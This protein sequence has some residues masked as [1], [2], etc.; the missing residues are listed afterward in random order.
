MWQGPEFTQFCKEEDRKEMDPTCPV[1]ESIDT[2][3]EFDKAYE[4]FIEETYGLPLVPPEEIEVPDWRVFLSLSHSLNVHFS[5][6][7]GPSTLNPEP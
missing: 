4:E 6:W 2:S 3:E 1:S 5:G 7:P